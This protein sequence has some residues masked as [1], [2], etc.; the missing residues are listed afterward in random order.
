MPEIK[1]DTTL[2]SIVKDY[3]ERNDYD[4]LYNDNCS[5]HKSD[6]FP[7]SYCCREGDCRPGYL[8]TCSESCPDGFDFCIRQDK[9]DEC[10]HE[11]ESDE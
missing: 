8:V 6:L 7:E 9:N 4:G 11:E 5:C 2:K 10:E 1:E 3:L